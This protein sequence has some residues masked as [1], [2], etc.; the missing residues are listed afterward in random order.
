MHIKLSE[1]YKKYNN[2]P[3]SYRT[4][5]IFCFDDIGAFPWSDL[6]IKALVQRLR[7]QTKVNPSFS[8]YLVS[9]TTSSNRE[10]IPAQEKQG[11]GRPKKKRRNIAKE[12]LHVHCMCVSTD[13]SKSPHADAA[14]VLKTIRKK[15]KAHLISDKERYFVNYMAQQAD[16]EYT[17]GCYNWD[18][19]KHE[20]PLQNED[21]AS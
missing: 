21:Y 13:E 12:P 19:Y 10:E 11:R 2:G 5:Y 16:H 9:S 6:A 15:R 7:R 3:K 14:A 17:D 8:W 18:Y 20:F 4:C 1:L